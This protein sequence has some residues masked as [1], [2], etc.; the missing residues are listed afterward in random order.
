MKLLV[1]KERAISVKAEVKQNGFRYDVNY[2]FNGSSLNKVRCNI[3][4][5]NNEYAGYMN[6]ANGS[7]SMSF[8]EGSDITAH[9]TLFQ[10]I[11]AEVR[12]ELK[13][14]V[15]IPSKIEKK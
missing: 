4:T 3:Y 14:E 8:P 2:D 5:E 10:G 9:S 1:E 13:P 15:V 12:E 7:T 11:V 6:L